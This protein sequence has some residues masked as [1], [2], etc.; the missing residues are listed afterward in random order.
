[1]KVEGVN[2]FYYLFLKYEKEFFIRVRGG[3]LVLYSYLEFLVCGF[4]WV[5]LCEVGFVFE[6]REGWEMWFW[7]L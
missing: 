1:M 6:D 2:Y 7:V 3:K 5:W 4:I